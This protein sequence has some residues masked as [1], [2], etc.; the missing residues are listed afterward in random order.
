MHAAAQLFRLP[1][2][3]H[4]LVLTLSLLFI[5]RV[6]FHIPL[7]G[8]DI[9]AIKESAG[10]ASGV[11]GLMNMF[12]GAALGSASLFSLG[13]M[14]YISASIIFSLLVKVVPA[15]EA[16]SKEGPSGHRKIN[17]YT[18]W[19]TVPICLLQGFF[20]WLGR[21]S[22]PAVLGEADPGAGMMFMMIASMTCGTLFIMWLGEQITEHG[23]GNGVSM[24]IMGGIIASLPTAVDLFRQ[25]L[26]DDQ[27]FY[28]TMMSLLAL[29]GVI[30]LVVVY[31]TKGQRRIP[32]QQA[33]LTR[34]RKVF[35]GQRSYLPLKVNQAGVMPIIFAS[36]LFIVPGV[37]GEAL[38]AT[39]LKNAF[40]PGSFI[41]IASYSGLIFFFCYFWTKLMFQPSEIS[42]NL[43]EHGSF[44]PG[45]RPGRRTTDYLEGVINRI[46]LAGAAFLAGI[47]LL[48]NL[49][50][51]NINVS[52]MISA[53]L[54]GTSILIVVGVALDFVEKINGMLVTRNYEAVG[55]GTGGGGG[56]ASKRR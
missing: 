15:L 40:A 46:T 39:W 24:I 14:P 22:S 28:S 50:T 29:W 36:A 23:I 12:T 43:K 52:P 21:L 10:G 9:A 26:N 30:I 38:N 16:L 55:A 13:V 27:T 25:T 34:G 53:F 1:E 56:W 41:Y 4:R 45:I 44:I 11:F 33:K 49:L 48:P 31:V 37:L 7:P 5:Y 3:R 35:G 19:A 51:R 8:V 54:G 18:R 6:G 2:L 47:A 17:Q 42:D 32:I 20:I